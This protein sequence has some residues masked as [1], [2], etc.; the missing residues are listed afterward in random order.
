MPDSLVTC[1]VCLTPNFTPRGLKAH[2]HKCK[3]G[4][5]LNR[6]TGLVEVLAPISAPSSSSP[7]VLSPIGEINAFHRRATAAADQARQSAS[8]ACHYAIL[9]GVRLEQLKASTQ[10]GD[11]GKLFSDRRNKSLTPNAAQIGKCAAFDVSQVAFEF[12]SDTAAK[13]MEVAKRIRLERRLS[14]K[15]V[16]RLDAIS[17]APDV[18]DKSRAWLNKLTEGQNRRQ[19]YLN[20]EVITSKDKAAAKPAAPAATR[21]VNSDAQLRMEDAREACF[22]WR[23]NWTKLVKR[24]HLD[25]L[26]QPELR[27]LHEFLA[28]CRDATKARLAPAAKSKP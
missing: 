12:S 23:E 3:G 14:G 20:L 18:D 7:V 28:T 25:D 9:C 24:G 27:E 1:P 22:V 15:A 21:P 10:H 16:K 6:Q 5:R 13:Y 2:K 11:W 4:T 19:L 26:P 8:E 17:K